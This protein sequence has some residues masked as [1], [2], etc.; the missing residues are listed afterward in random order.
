MTVLSSQPSIH[1]AAFEKTHPGP[2]RWFAVHVCVMSFKI[3]G[4]SSE[5]SA[6]MRIGKATDSFTGL[7]N[8]AAD[9]CH[10]HILRICKACGRSSEG[11]PHA[12]Y[13]GT[14]WLGDE[15][16][17]SLTDNACGPCRWKLSAQSRF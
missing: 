6:S 3:F 13:V 12:N 7:N 8:T 16:E 15:H 5:H 9:A 17:V 14:V 2:M 1:S 4:S 11:I 10:P